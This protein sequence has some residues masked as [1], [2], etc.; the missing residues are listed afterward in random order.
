MSLEYGKDGHRLARHLIHDP[1]VT[2]ENFANVGFSNSG[3]IRPAWGIAAALIARRRRRETHFRAA[4]RLSRAMK[5]PISLR[6]CR[7]RSLHRSF[8]DS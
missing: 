1:I 2:Q 7:A 4:S 6:S 5:R 3:T 8:I